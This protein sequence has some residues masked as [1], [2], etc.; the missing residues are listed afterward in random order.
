MA[1]RWLVHDKAKL[2]FV[3]GT[4][5]WQND[6]LKLA[7]HTVTSSVHDLSEDDWDSLTTKDEVSNGGYTAGGVV[8]AA[9]GG[10]L[11]ESGGILT[12]D[13]AASQVQ[14]TATGTDLVCAFA[15]IYANIT[16]K[17]IIATNALAGGSGA[18]SVASTVGN[19]FTLRFSDSGLF[20][21][22]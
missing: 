6:E 15:C 14:W 16:G 22:N 18:S 7:L 8:L 11:A 19:N 9:S 3:D 21:M 10:T 13:V 20:R 17:P 4:V 2:Y 5:D 1:G 12:F